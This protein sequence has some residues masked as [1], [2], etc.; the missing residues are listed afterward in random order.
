MARAALE[1]GAVLVLC[2]Q[3]VSGLLFV[4]CVAEVLDAGFLVALVL[5]LLLLH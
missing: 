2:C 4:L 3:I 1:S 5:L